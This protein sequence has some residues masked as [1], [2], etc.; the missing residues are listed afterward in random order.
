M[1]LEKAAGICMNLNHIYRN[2]RKYNLVTKIL[3]ANS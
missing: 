2:M 1:V 3:Q